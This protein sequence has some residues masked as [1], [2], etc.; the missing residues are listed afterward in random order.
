MAL[1]GSGSLHGTVCHGCSLRTA[2][3]STPASNSRIFCWKLLHYRA[4]QENSADGRQPSHNTFR[5]VSVNFLYLPHNIVQIFP[6]SMG[7]IYKK[8]YP[9]GF[10][11][12]P[13]YLPLL[14]LLCDAPG[15]K[16]FLRVLFFLCPFPFRAGRESISQHMRTGLLRQCLL[17]WSSEEDSHSSLLCCCPPAHGPASGIAAAGCNA[18]TKGTTASRPLA[19]TGTHSTLPLDSGCTASE[20]TMCWKHPLFIC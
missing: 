10:F 13:K 7:T 3:L 12:P 15:L 16:S 8:C 18:L 4:Q 5:K 2:L 19:A 17:E 11:F 14:P 20:H 6:Y 1:P 9:V